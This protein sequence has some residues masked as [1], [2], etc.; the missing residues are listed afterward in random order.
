MKNGS[1]KNDVARANNRQQKRGKFLNN[2]QIPVVMD[3]NNNS[4]DNDDENNMPLDDLIESR[5]LRLFKM[6]VSIS[7]MMTMLIIFAFLT[8]AR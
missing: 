8:M 4:D 2:R 3:S 7:M 1:N 5:N 6:L